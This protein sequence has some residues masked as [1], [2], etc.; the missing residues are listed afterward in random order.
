[1]NA[2]RARDLA[3][4]S[5]MKAVMPLL[6]MMCAAVLAVAQGPGRDSDLTIKIR[7]LEFSRFNAEQHKDIGALNQIFDDGLMLADPNGLL[8]N[9]AQFL[10]VTR[11]PD[12][13]ILRMAPEEM[14]VRVSGDV[15]TVV[16]TY[17]ERG[18]RAGIPY[19]RRC[20]FIDTWTWTRGRWLCIASTA[21][22]T[23][24]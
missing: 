11:A 5:R 22:S 19:S 16:G 14:A 6:G 18:M 10:S 12:I 2:N 4:G 23:V 9:K 17:V 20:R 8:L 24:R 1:M 21:S 15:V 3:R 13:T 7:S